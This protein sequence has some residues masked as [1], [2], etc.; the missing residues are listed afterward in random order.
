MELHQR[1]KNA[2]T[3]R[4]GR[5]KDEEEEKRER[6]RDASSASL[7]RNEIRAWQQMERINEVASG[8]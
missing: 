7:H 1:S 8:K 5:R 3:L 2:K 6:E 4:R